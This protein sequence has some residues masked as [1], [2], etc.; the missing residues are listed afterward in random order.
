M[1]KE[2]CNHQPTGVLNC[3]SRS[4]HQSLQALFSPRGLVQSG[5]KCSGKPK[6][7]STFRSHLHKAP[8]DAF[9]ATHFL[10]N[11]H[12]DGPFPTFPSLIKLDDWPCYSSWVSAGGTSVG[13][14]PAFCKNLYRSWSCGWMEKMERTMEKQYTAKVNAYSVWPLEIEHSNSEPRINMVQTSKTLNFHVF[15]WFSILAN[16]QCMLE[17]SRYKVFG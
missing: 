9:Q 8:H 7:R 11:L 3:R 13:R 15:P 2:L 17:D 6:Q 10:C 5:R 14:D 12:R 16:P 4:L 1:A